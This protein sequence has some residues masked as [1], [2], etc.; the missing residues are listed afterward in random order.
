MHSV[1]EYSR[2]GGYS[3]TSDGITINHIN[4]LAMRARS[5]S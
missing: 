3:S 5:S 1:E 4:V 2:S